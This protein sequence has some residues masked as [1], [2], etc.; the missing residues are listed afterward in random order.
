MVN[1][2]AY[3]QRLCP[4]ARVVFLLAGVALAS[5]CASDTVREGRGG[6]FLILDALEASSGAEES[7]VFSTV[8]QSD[9]QTGGGVFE[10]PGRVQMR[11]ALK[12]VGTPGNPTQPTT[13]NFITV[14]R[15]RVTFRRSDGRNQPGVDLPYGFDGAAT[16]TVGLA[17]TSATF[18]IVRA[19]AKLEPPLMNMRGLGGAVAISTLADVTFFGRDQAG[20][21]VSVTGTI[22]INFADWAD[23][24]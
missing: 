15:Y 6:S 12:D 20:N 23:P 1:V 3:G 22:S 21:E 5:S 19:Q 17:P 11:L 2:S 7:P 18:S 8:L 14:N 4:A 13:N 24:Q 16:F 10:D 9:V